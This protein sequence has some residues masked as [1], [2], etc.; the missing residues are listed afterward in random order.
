M[1]ICTAKAQL[2]ADGFPSEEIRDIVIDRLVIDTTAYM[3][4]GE[5]FKSEEGGYGFNLTLECGRTCLRKKLH[6]MGFSN[7]I[8]FNGS[9]KE[10]S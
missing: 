9:C 6:E 4:Q 1:A 8:I 3:G 2:N 5:K 7:K 10:R